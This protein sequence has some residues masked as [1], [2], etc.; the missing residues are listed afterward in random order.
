MRNCERTIK[1]NVAE[2]I[3]DYEAW[4]GAIYRQERPKTFDE[5][6]ENAEELYKA[7]LKVKYY[8]GELR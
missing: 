8:L 6:L 4:S 5:A 2:A 3:D 1:Q 7:L